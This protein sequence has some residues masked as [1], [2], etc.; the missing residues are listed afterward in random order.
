MEK[1]TE[2]EE[3]IA[4]WEGFCEKAEKKMHELEKETDI[5]KIK[6]MFRAYQEEVKKAHDVFRDVAE[7]HL[8]KSE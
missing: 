5:E 4:L 3:K 2:L 8:R 6:V 1:K 7:N